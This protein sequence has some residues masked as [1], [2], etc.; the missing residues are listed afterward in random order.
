MCGICGFNWKDEKILVQMLESIK[1]RGP[2]DQGKFESSHFSLG[3]NRLSIIDLSKK[4]KNP[5]WN[6]DKTKCII[7][8]GEIYNYQ[9]LKKDLQK[10]GHKFQTKTDTEVILLGYEEYK[11]KI[12]EKLNGMFAF[13]IY[14]KKNN[15]LFI[16]RDRLGIKPLYYYYKDKKFIFASEIKAIL[17]HEI[18]RIPNYDS[19]TEYL[20]F[21]NILD[22]KTFFQGIRLLLPG[23]YLT[24]INNNLEIKEYW[25]PKFNYKKRTYGEL[26]KEFRKILTKSVK[27]HMISDVEVGSYLSG[28]FDSGSITTLASK[29][30]KKQLN[31]FTCKFDIKGEFDETPCSRAVS[32]QIN[33]KNYEIEITKE[34][35][36]KNI[37]NMIYHLD[38]P[39]VGIPVISQYHLSQLVSKHVKVVLTGHSGDE[40]FAG[41]PVFQAKRY[42]QMLKNNPLNIFEVLYKTLKDKKRLNILYYL[43]LPKIYS[44]I[45]HGIIII[46]PEKEKKKL[47]TKSF[48]NK[49][50][51]YSPHKCI[52]KV[53][54]NEKLNEIEKLQF[55]Y[56]KT[57]LPSLFI[58]EDKMGMAHSIEAR[59]P[60]CDNEM[61]DF[62]LSV[63]I[64]Q[65]LRNNDLKGIVKNGMKGIIPEILYK[66][67]KRGFPTPLGPWLDKGLK[68][69][70]SQILLNKKAL[71]RGIYKKDYVKKLLQ[72]TD[73]W[74]ANKLWC[75][76]NLELWFQ[77]Y[78]D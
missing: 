49:T 78:I 70:F 1:H 6:K 27:R 51:H 35:F 59:I 20:T 15:T 10:K 77:T 55:L 71:S 62:A 63:P 48:L 9:E 42:K 44:E 2:D 73:F 30:T 76:L 4:G 5:I 19:I 34:D 26:L 36:L 58:A 29:E 46:Y 17:K 32:K 45:K 37:K 33:A 24:L 22:D 3:H 41:Y 67:E 50:K 39:K 14:D 43:L 47:L 56:L 54:K 57:Y 16:A 72:K 7:Y 21:Q 68:I 75:L 8:N 28:G 12:L 74:T 25:K 31:T 53:F 38:E 52:K 61:V 23:H 64:N 60:F 65:K 40:L 13:A 18:K 11:E 69:Y 66:Q